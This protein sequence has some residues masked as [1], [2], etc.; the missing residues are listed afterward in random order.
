MEPQPV[1]AKPKSKIPWWLIVIVVLLVMIVPIGIIAA[2][3]LVS[4][5]SARGKATDARI[6]SDVSQMRNVAENYNSQH[7]TYKGF[8][9]DPTAKTILSDVQKSGSKINENT[10]DTTYVIYATLPDTKKV[11]CADYNGSGEEVN[12]VSSTQTSCP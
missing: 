6:M 3:V 12:S 2:M 8:E 5:S 1:Q 11:F 9:T 10:T 7:S 4:L